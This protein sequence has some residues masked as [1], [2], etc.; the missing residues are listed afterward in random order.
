[1]PKNTGYIK[2]HRNILNWQWYQDTNTARVFLHLLLK[3]NHKDNKWQ[4]LQ[5]KKGQLVT[6]RDILAKEL[7]ISAQS[8][9]TALAKLASINQQATSRAQMP[10]QAYT[11]TNTQN[12]LENYD[13]KSTSEIT[14]KSTNRFSLITIVNWDVYQ[15][16]STSKSTSK[17]TNNQPTSNHKQ[18]CIKNVKNIKNI[19][20]LKIEEGM[21]SIRDSLI[22][23]GVLK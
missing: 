15:G 16:S 17:S 14:I 12:I 20:N 6:S 11:T 4:G 8:V 5:V 10:F 2:L 22:Q 18:E 13:K 19:S 9:R 21:K 23:K 7:D 1:M 3:A